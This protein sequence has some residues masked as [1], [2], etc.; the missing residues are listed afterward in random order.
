LEGS[1]V[2]TEPSA[3]LVLDAFTDLGEDRGAEQA[4]K[5]GLLF[6][7]CLQQYADMTG[8]S[9][10]FGQ[11]GRGYTHRSYPAMAWLNLRGLEGS[12]TLV[13][14]LQD[15][16]NDKGIEYKCRTSPNVTAWRFRLYLREKYDPFK[17]DSLELREDSTSTD[18]LIWFGTFSHTVSP[19]KV[20]SSAARVEQGSGK[21]RLR[22]LV[23]SIAEL[24]ESSAPLVSAAKAKRVAKASWQAASAGFPPVYRRPNIFTLQKVEPSLIL[25]LGYLL[26]FTFE[27]FVGGFKCRD[28]LW[29]A[30][31]DA[32]KIE[33]KEM[34]P[35][36]YWIP[37]WKF[38][39]PERRDNIE[40][41]LKK[42]N[43]IAR[44]RDDNNKAEKLAWADKVFVLFQR[45]AEEG[46]IAYH[47]DSQ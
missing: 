34:F 42:F 12:C 40:S 31:M 36:M 16:Y 38:D 28:A 23:E 39:D 14:A 9:A 26:G 2:V 7:Q 20:W 1:E 47:G 21:K 27:R 29:V 43:D 25:V 41:D 13:K 15:V 37:G 4:M 24:T 6:G 22:P 33:I 46:V 45:A 17:K 5:G 30:V 44:F 10:D 19:K 8:K 11:R 32:M 3:N 35:G 18:D